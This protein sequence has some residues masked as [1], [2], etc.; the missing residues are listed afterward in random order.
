MS[1]RR[2][3]RAET[4]PQERATDVDLVALGRQMAARKKVSRFRSEGLPLP[5]RDD[6]RG[7]IGMRR[8]PS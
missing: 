3:S 1:R 7:G 2:R 5:C 8:A 4:L 6:E